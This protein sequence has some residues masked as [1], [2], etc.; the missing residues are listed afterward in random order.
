MCYSINYIL[1]HVLTSKL[2]L[3][4]IINSSY[5]ANNSQSTTML[6]LYVAEVAMSYN[7]VEILM[8]DG[9]MPVTFYVINMSLSTIW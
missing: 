2:K 9:Q 6:K 7:L 3:T 4:I 1:F 8:F 5:D